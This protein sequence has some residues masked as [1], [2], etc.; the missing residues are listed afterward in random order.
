MRYMEYEFPN[1]NMH[2]A[3]QQFML[4][5]KYLVAPVVHKCSRT[6][7]VLLPKGKWKSMLNDKVYEG[8]NKQTFKVPLNKLLVLEKV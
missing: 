6:K 7:T 8:G 4:G 5:D 1:Q 2:R 3:K